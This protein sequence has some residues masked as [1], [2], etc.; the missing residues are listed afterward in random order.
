MHPASRSGLETVMLASS[1]VSM[2][3]S[4]FGPL[5]HLHCSSSEN[6]VL[7]NFLPTPQP[8]LIAVVT[9]HGVSKANES[10][11]IPL[12]GLPMGLI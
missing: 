6:R 8:A 10:S 9:I 7:S 1:L 2:L 12:T 4:I 5:Q 3:V 11:L